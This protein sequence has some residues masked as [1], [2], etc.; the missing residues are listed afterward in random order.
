ML[1][2]FFAASVLLVLVSCLPLLLLFLWLLLKTQLRWQVVGGPT[3]YLVPRASSG[4]RAR[5][6][7]IHTQ[8]LSFP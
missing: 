3:G 6:T 8:R 1:V 7:H 4:C 2:R 5:L